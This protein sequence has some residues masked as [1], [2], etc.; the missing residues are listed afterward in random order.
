LVK[1]QAERPCFELH[2][3]SSILLIENLPDSNN[4]IY[5]LDWSTRKID[6]IDIPV[7]KL[8]KLVR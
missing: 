7:E 3:R 4:V 5:K 1:I 6:K 2:S 8:G